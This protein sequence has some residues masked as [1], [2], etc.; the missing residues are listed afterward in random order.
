MFRVDYDGFP[1][2][3]LPSCGLYEV[4]LVFET[5]CVFSHQ[6]SAIGYASKSITMRESNA[7]ENQLMIHVASIQ[8]SCESRKEYA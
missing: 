1:R 6:P 5:S 7:P 4:M 8:L 2:K 3:N